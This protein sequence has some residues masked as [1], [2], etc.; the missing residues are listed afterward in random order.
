V[1][2]KLRHLARASYHYLFPR[3]VLARYV[4]NHVADEI[5]MDYLELLADPDRGA[6]DVGA[7]LGRYSIRLAALT[8]RVWAFEP[9][10]R[11]SRILE[12]SLPGNV[13]VK[14]AAVSNRHGT[15][16]LRVPL[17]RDQQIESLGT[18]EIMGDVGAYR[19]IR[20]PM[21]TLDG[22]SSENIGFIKIDVEGHELSVVEG[23]LKLLAAQRPIVLVEADEHHK[24]GTTSDLFK[25]M[26]FAGYQGVFILRNSVRII[27]DFDPETMQNEKDLRS[28]APRKECPYVNNF[29]FAPE[30]SAFSSLHERLS[31]RMRPLSRMR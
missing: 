6:V 12:K 18:L 24:A 21:L 15:I 8:Q 3:L 29:I 27:S 19:T 20:V 30:G 13:I 5:E 17:K 4:H 10:P 1:I 28:G 22:L 7:N 26:A 9:H 23:G 14:Q 2:G 31:A 25:L 16:E 11:L